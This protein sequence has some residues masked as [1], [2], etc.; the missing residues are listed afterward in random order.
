MLD[1]PQPNG[2]GYL[3]VF[4]SEIVG[5]WT[6]DPVFGSFPTHAQLAQR[7]MDGFSADQATGD[8]Y[9]YAHLGCQIQR[10]NAGFFPEGA[11]TLM[12]ECAES[13]A[14]WRIED[15]MSSVRAGG[16]R[17]QRPE[18]SLVKLVNGVANGLIRATQTLSYLSGWFVVCAGEQHLTAADGEAL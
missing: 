6:G 18:S 9:F 15:L 16:F 1:G 3:A 2:S 5:I 11:R 8:A 14:C 4:F 12:E 17:V 7:I 13:F 10:P